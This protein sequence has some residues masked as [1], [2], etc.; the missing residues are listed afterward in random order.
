MYEEARSDSN[1]YGGS[2]SSY[3]LSDPYG[4]EDYDDP[5]DF[6]D[7]WAEEFGDG[8]CATASGWL[9]IPRPNANVSPITRIF[10]SLNP[11]LEIIFIPLI[12]II[13]KTVMIAPPSTAFGIAEKNSTEFWEKSGNHQDKCT[14]S[15]TPFIYN[16]CHGNDS[17][18]LTECSIW[19]SIEYGCC[20]RTE[21][22]GK[23]GSGSVS[24]GLQSG[25]YK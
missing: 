10:R 3:H 21:S 15:N 11:A 2:T 12:R 9:A 7:E 18:V 19:K 16:L 20:C 5:D 17:S 23:D 14:G 6:A 24:D 8:S 1:Y 22:I 13:P 25:C 4:V